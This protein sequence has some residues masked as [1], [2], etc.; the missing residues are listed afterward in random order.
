MLKIPT[1]KIKKLIKTKMLKHCAYKLLHSKK[2]KLF[3]QNHYYN[4]ICF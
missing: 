1:L 4:N 3:K 2:S